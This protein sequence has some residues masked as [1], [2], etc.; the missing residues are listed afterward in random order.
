MVETRLPSFKAYDI[1]G[2]VPG[3][4]NEDMAY[5]VGRAYVAEMRPSGSVAVGQDIRETSESF[6]RALSRGITDAGGDVLDI[7]V[8]GTEMVYFASSMKGV[9]GGVM[10]TASHNPKDY[11]GIKMVRRGARPVSEDTGLLDIE[12]RVRTGDLPP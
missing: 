4:L 10:I 5:A 6:F 3:E 1:R 12:R 9:D 11:N 2:K 7:G 8:C